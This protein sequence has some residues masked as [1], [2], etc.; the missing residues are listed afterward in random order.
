LL[1]PPK[2]GASWEGFALEEVIRQNGADEDEVYFWAVH[3][4]AEL[5]LL[6]VR[7]G[8]KLGFEFEYGS[9]PGMTS[10]LGRAY[11]LLAPDNITVVY[12]GDKDYRL[13]D[14]IWVR[15]LKGYLA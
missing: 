5:D 3:H 6:I 11:E 1:V 2:L 12:P 14:N 7:G 13:A 9:T 4:Q 8:Q 10:S 15:G